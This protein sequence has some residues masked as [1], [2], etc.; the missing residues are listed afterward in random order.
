MGWPEAVAVT[1]G[2]SATG[3]LPPEKIVPPTDLM[4]RH[5]P[6]WSPYTYWEPVE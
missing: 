6:V 2:E 3:L 5:V 4:D 1:A